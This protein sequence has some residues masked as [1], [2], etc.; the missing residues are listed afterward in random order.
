MRGLGR[1]RGFEVV[2]E[3]SAFSD[4]VLMSRIVERIHRIF[5]AVEGKRIDPLEAENSRLRDEVEE[6]EDDIRALEDKLKIAETRLGEAED[7]INEA[8]DELLQQINEL[9]GEKSGEGFD[10]L[11][12]AVEALIADYCDALEELDDES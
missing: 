12:S 2:D 8:N 9:L 5:E 10:D 7:S 6:L 11:P 3:Y 1:G 4:E